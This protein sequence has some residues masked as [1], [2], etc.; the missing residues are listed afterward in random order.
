MG[1]EFKLFDNWKDLPDG[2]NYIYCWTCGG[3][4]ACHQWKV[5]T[6]QSTLWE[7]DWVCDP[8]PGDWDDMVE[9]ALEAAKEYGA[10]YVYGEWSLNVLARYQA[11]QEAEEKEQC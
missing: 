11:A 2:K 8:E 10:D 1:L 7:G 5:Q 3:G 9:K 6:G 4:C